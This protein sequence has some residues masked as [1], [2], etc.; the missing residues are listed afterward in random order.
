MCCIRGGISYSYC[1]SQLGDSSSD[2]LLVRLRGEVR[3]ILPSTVERLT[4]QSCSPLQ[5]CV[6]EIASVEAGLGGRGVDGKC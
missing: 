1:G 5:C 2:G 4:D 3:V 6:G